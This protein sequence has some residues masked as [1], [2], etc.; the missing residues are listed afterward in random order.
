VP[1]LD[2]TGPAICRGTITPVPR[3]RCLLSAL[4]GGL[5]ILFVD[6]NAGSLKHFVRLLRA[7][8]AQKPA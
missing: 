4:A 5:V 7:R 6:I 1:N 2:F 3:R 8:L